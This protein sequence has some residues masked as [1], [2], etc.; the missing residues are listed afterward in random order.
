MNIVY[1]LSKYPKLKEQME[2]HI[3]QYPDEDVHDTINRM[4][5]ISSV[6]LVV[7]AYQLSI[8]KPTDVTKAAF[9]SIN[10]YYRDIIE[11]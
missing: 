6:P 5:A 9:E 8:S 3:S 2:N 4:T 10:R 11:E 7:V 1:K